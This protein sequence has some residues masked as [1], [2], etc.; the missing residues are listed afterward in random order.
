[1]YAISKFAKDIVEVRDNLQRAMEIEVP[2][3]EER[4]VEKGYPVS[5][6]V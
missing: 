5:E 3:G 2:E 6:Y 1:M 4:D